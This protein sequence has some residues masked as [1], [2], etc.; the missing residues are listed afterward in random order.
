MKKILTILLSV[1]MVLSLAACAKKEEAPVEEQPQAEEKLVPDPVTAKNNYADFVAAAN[2][3]ELEILMSVQDHQAYWEDNG[4]GKCTVYGQDDD[5]GYFVYEMKCDKALADV[6]LPGTLIKVTGY[7]SEWSGELELMDATAEF[8]DVGGNAG[9]VY[10]PKDVTDKVGTDDLINFMNQ[11]VAIKG[12]E[13]TN[14]SKKDSEYD[15]DLYISVKLNGAEFDLCVENYLTDPSTEVYKTAE[16]LKVGD[17]ID[18]TGYL[19]WYNGP[20]PHVTAI[21]VK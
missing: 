13:V 5:G 18:I 12:L 17:V 3:T 21:T 15:P 9:K 6:L 7:K 19:Y 10:D 16:G 14:L 20:N 4:Q 11:K 8:C 1:L 2:D